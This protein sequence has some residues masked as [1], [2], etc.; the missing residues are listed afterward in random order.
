MSNNVN[1]QLFE[2]AAEMID[3]WTGTLHDRLIQRALDSNDLEALDYHVRNAEAEM[4]LQEDNPIE[5]VQN[6]Y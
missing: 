4:R 6:V 1:T 2:R 3:Y 5:E